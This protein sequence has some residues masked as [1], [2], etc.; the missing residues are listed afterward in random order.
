[1]LLLFRP[2]FPQKKGKF[3]RLSDEDR[4][5]VLNACKLFPI[6]RIEHE[7]FVEEEEKDFDDEEPA[8]GAATAVADDTNLGKK[9]FEQDLATLR[10]TI[11][12]ENVKEGEHAP[13]VYAPLFPKTIQE[14][15]W[16]ILTDKPITSSDPRRPAPEVQIQAVEKVFTL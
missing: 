7:L 9:I 14:G 11:T 2:F 1:M 15:L 3:A 10:V 16:V 13:P 6:Y 12:R 5:D 4:Q 8:E